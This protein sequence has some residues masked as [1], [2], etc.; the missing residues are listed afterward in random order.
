MFEVVNTS[1]FLPVVAVPV[2]LPIT[3]PKWT[4]SIVAAEIV[5]NDPANTS[6][7]LVP[8]L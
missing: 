4:P 2:T 7:V 3:L 8:A 5:P 1:T 6:F